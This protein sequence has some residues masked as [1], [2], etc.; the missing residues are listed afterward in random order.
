MKRWAMKKRATICNSQVATIGVLIVSAP[1]Q[2]QEPTAAPRALID[3]VIIV[4]GTRAPDRSRLE[5]ASP[6]DVLTSEMLNEQGSTELAEALSNVVPSINFPRPAVSD[7]TDHIRPAV[8][9]GLA[10]DQTLVLV[11]SKRRHQSALV[12]INNTFGRGSSA[13]D[14]NAI[15]VAAIESVEVL[16]DGASAQYGSDAIAG[17]VNVRLREAR[18]GGNASVTF[19]QYD[20]SVEPART[21]YSQSDGQTVTASAWLGLPLSAEGFLTLSAEFRDRDPTSRGDLDPRVNVV[22]S[23]YGDSEVQDGT[24]Y[25]N[26]GMPLGGTWSLYGWAGYQTRDGSAAA[27]PR[28]LT[29]TTPNA[30]VDPAIYPNGFLPIITSDI[31]DYTAAFGFKGQL[32]GWAADTSLV[33]GKNEFDFGVENSLNATIPNSQTTFDSGGLEYDQAVFNFGLS[34][35][36]DWGFARPA[37]VAVGV[38]ARRESYA[39]RAG[40]P[41]SYIQGPINM[42]GAGVP[43]PGAQGFPGFSPANVVDQSRNAEGVYVDIET[44]ITE[45]FLASVALRGEHYSDFGSN[46]TGKLSVRY[47]F[48]PA[49]ALRATGSNGFRAPSLQQSFLTNVSTTFLGGQQVNSGLFAPTSAVAQALGASPLDAEKSINASL[50][51]VYQAGNFE[52]TVDAYQIKI[53]DRIVLSENLNGP[54]FARADIAALIAPFGVGSARFFLNGVDTRTRGVDTV[55][56]YSFAFAGKLDLTASSNFNSTTVT[57]LP[58]TGVLSTLNPPAVLFASVNQVA[59]EDGTPSNKT[60]LAADWMTPMGM[61][62][63]AASLKATRYGSVTDPGTVNDPT[64]VFALQRYTM[65]AKTLVDLEFRAKIGMHFSAALGADNVL[66]TYPDPVPLAFNNNGLLG[67]SRYAPF[68]FNGRFVYTRFGWNW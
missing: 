42:R 1:L 46:G 24:F 21:S 40:E 15:P 64:G 49:F 68:G 35:G 41:N 65:D 43:S 56:K 5:T 17:V 50:G 22:N 36:F 13:V 29:A 59:F 33:Y 14:F 67:F 45:K 58:T 20:T 12:N 44:Q 48:T 55:L 9:R 61:G 52:A 34:R 26:A 54:P 2:A 7:G 60:S 10:P 47:D 18:R 51:A 63:F 39:I 6:V 19:G 25:L 31:A 37:N 28:V 8:L 62:M 32:A 3:E 4:T 53:D 23:R 11:N 16:R 27:T 57:Q 38:E 30:N 66:D